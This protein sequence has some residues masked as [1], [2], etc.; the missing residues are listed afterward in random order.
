V[1]KSAAAPSSPVWG[2]VSGSLSEPAVSVQVSFGVAGPVRTSV[3]VLAENGV[4]AAF[5][6]TCSVSVKAWPSSAEIV[7]TLPKYVTSKPV[8]L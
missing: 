8:P 5:V 3:D 4:A 2:T 7:T 1:T 6:V